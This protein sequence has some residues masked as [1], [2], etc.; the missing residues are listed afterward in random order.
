MTII[1]KIEYTDAPTAWKYIGDRYAF[2]TTKLIALETIARWVAEGKAIGHYKS[3]AG[4]VE[5]W[6]IE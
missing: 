2:R 5:E 3:D 1:R 4:D 6:I